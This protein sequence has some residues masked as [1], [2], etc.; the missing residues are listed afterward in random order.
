MRFHEGKE[1]KR[2]LGPPKTVDQSHELPMITADH[3]DVFGSPQI[4]DLAVLA[5]HD[6]PGA[7][8]K[9]QNKDA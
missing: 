4:Q 7:A 5:S 3:R 1:L 6:M 2:S 9:C 8:G